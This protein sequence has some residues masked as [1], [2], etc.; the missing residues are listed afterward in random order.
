MK[1]ITKDIFG[2]LAVLVLGGLLVL[3]L[4]YLAQVN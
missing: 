4:W 3:V 1:K 2:C